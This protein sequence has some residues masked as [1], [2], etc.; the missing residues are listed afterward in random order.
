[1]KQIE[2]APVKEKTRALAVIHDDDERF[3]WNDYIPD[4]DQ[5]GLAFVATTTLVTFN[6]ERDIAHVRMNRIY[7]AYKEAKKEKRWDAERECYLDP[8]GIFLQIQIGL[9]LRR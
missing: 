9:I 3:N 1:M 6:R 5:Q 7:R 4:E 8:K 2:E